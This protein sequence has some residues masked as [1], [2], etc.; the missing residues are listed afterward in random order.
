MACSAGAVQIYIEGETGGGGKQI[1]ISFSFSHPRLRLAS[2]C[3]AQHFLAMWK[4][5]GSARRVL[6][7]QSIE[8]AV[9]EDLA[10]C[11]VACAGAALADFSSREGVLNPRLAFLFLSLFP[12]LSLSLCATYNAIMCSVSGGHRRQHAPLCND[13]TPLMLSATF[14]PMD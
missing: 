5:S 2:G 8:N 12:S 4:E 14:G 9:G 3:A 1:A 10:L 13:P 11:R 7:Q 6:R